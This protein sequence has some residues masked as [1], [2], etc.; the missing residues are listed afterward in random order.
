MDLSNRPRH[1]HRALARARAESRVESGLTPFQS[2][3]AEMQARPASQPDFD[4][5][6]DDVV[7][8]SYG[9]P[10]CLDAAAQDLGSLDERSQPSGPPLAFLA[11]TIAEQAESSQ[12]I[13]PELRAALNQCILRAVEA[14]KAAGSLPG[15]CT[16]GR[17][18]QNP[19]ELIESL[20][21]VVAS[22]GAGEGDLEEHSYTLEP[23]PA[24]RRAEL[25]GKFRQRP[26]VTI[27]PNG[28]RVQY[29]GLG[30]EIVKDAI[31]RVREVKSRGGITI[32]FE[33]DRAGNLD[34][35][36][37][38]EADGRPHSEGRR[39]RHGVVVR[40][41]D[42]RV[43]ALGELMTVDPLGCLCIHNH[44]GQFVSLDLIRGLHIERRCL[45]DWQGVWQTLTAI[46]AHDGFRM[47]TRFHEIKSAADDQY[48]TCL[49]SCPSPLRFY[50]RDGSVIAFHSEDDLRGLRPSRVL[51]P[52]SVHV[53]LPLRGKRQAGTAWEAAQ[54][55]LEMIS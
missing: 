49:Q 29:P 6:T 27:M 7:L 41:P 21:R 3:K 26:A 9:E 31:G 25:R 5:R 37:R 20:K 54:E 38:I 1:T 40:D 47:A 14:A 17:A 46:F 10:L 53:E 39:D 34:S 8:K 12:G 35:F 22:S 19:Q 28:Q 16:A 18:A 42:G 30:G 11:E 45:P 43:R 24:R 33:Y 48:E 15:D 55:Y 44:D 32:C 2:L 51:P 13:S 52:G 50:G 36:Y 23:L 4:K